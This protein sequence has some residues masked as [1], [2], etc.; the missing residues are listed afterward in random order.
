MRSC[1][2]GRK[3]VEGASL[4]CARGVHGEYP[5]SSDI[6]L[7]LCLRTG[8]VDEVDGAGGVEDA[9]KLL[10]TPGYCHGVGVFG[11]Q[12]NRGIRG[13]GGPRSSEKRMD[14][15]TESYRTREHEGATRYPN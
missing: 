6:L 8:V 15:S 5:R 14:R 11:F 3:A 4:I 7:G 9:A 12:R 2:P 13:L 1:H 10:A